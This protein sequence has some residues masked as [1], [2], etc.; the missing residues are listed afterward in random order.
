MH[1]QA[2]LHELTF[3][4]PHAHTAHALKYVH[5]RAHMD[6]RTR[7][8]ADTCAHACKHTHTHAC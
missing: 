7:T 3:T 1:T 4:H 6:A 5:M 8:L 2:Y